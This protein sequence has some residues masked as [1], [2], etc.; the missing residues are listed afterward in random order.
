M[1]EPEGPPRDPAFPAPPGLRLAEMSLLSDQ[2]DETGRLL[3]EDAAPKGAKKKATRYGVQMKAVRCEY[4]DTPSRYGGTMNTSAYEALRQ[5]TAQMLDGFA[6]LS[7]R[8]FEVDPSTRSTVRGL[9]D[10]SYLGVNLPLV[11]FHRA[12][13]PI[14]PHGGLPSYVAS[15]FKASRGIFS[16]AVDMLNRKGPPSRTTS[17]GEAL[18]FADR[19]GHLAR[20]ESGRVCAAPTRLI[21][22]TISVI[23]TAEGADPEESKLR[24]LVGFDQLW[25]FCRLQDAFG[26]A[27]SNY[28]QILNDLVESGDVGDPYELFGSLVFDG[29]RRLPFGD[30]TEGL[31]HQANA[32]QVALNQVLGRAGGAPPVT[33]ED[34]LNML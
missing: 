28:G 19:E 29:R 25:E 13:D 15:I 34:V 17:V 3:L 31:L 4:K 26:H 18:E 33:F 32:T 20:A 22:R 12:R 14:A 2:R 5:D 6:W 11:L 27:L 1:R 8:R 24:E 7:R 23:L 16:A 10:T 21:E 9:F 30:V